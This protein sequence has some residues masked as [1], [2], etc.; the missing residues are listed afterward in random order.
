MVTCNH[1]HLL[2]VDDGERDVIPKSMKLVAGR[3]AQEYNQRKHRKG[4]FWEDRYHATAVENGDHLARCMVYMDTN[5]V[6][7]GAEDH[8]SQWS[9]CGYNEI[10]EPRRKNVLID[11]DRLQRLLGFGS[12]EKLVRNHKGWID[13]YLGNANKEREEEWTDSIAVGN[14]PFV[15]KVKD[16]L[17]FRGKGRKITRSGEGFQ[18]REEAS[19]YNE[20]FG[21]KKEDI[22][23]K[24]IYFWDL[25]V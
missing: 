14:R 17:G 9:F 20:F 19:G 23:P 18:V 11:Y 4:A 10:Q 13:E 7:A 6:R 8:P 15:Q 1:V 2:V 3:T 5:M 22:G 16:I 25:N 21:A 24:S 12:Y